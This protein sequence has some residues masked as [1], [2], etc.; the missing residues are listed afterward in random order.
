[1]RTVDE[2]HSV[3]YS[4]MPQVTVTVPGVSHLFGGFSD[5]CEGFSVCAANGFT[6]EAALSLRDDQTVRLYNTMTSE[7]K[8]FSLN[9]L[10][11]RREDRWSNYAKG[12]IEKLRESGLDL[13]GLNVTL[14]GP[15]L[16]ADA[17]VVACALGTALA[18]GLNEMFGLKHDLGAISRLVYMAGTVFCQEQCRLTDAIVMTGAGAGQLMLFDNRSM[19]CS[20]IEYTRPGSGARFVTIDG[21]IP[22]QT[23][24]EELLSQRIQMKE[25]FGYL[26]SRYPGVSFREI[27]ESD[28]TE[29]SFR[30]DELHRHICT[31]ILEASRLSR[32]AF[33]LIGNRDWQGLGKIMNHL[34]KGLRDRLDLT[35][36]EV[37]WLA[38][39][40]NELTGCLGILTMQTGL[41][42]VMLALMDDEAVRSYAERLAE[43][44]R[45]FGFRAALADFTCCGPASVERH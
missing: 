1:M 8:R 24:R 20:T 31:Y 25:A 44:E 3:E 4:Q 13:P 28:L 19:E 22:P 41:G 14:A 15:L 17:P 12:V 11:F 6:L 2:K 23:L 43:Y 32:D 27:P 7:R 16:A 40:A 45:I 38:K 37:D 42:G 33:R 21:R 34:Q 5:F 39:R 29:R 18:L 35:C 30:I 9:A 26:R 36:P 10:K